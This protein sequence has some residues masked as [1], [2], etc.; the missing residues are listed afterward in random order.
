[1]TEISL[2]YADEKVCF[3]LTEHGKYKKRKLGPV[4]PTRFGV[5]RL[6]LWFLP[7]YDP[8]LVGIRLIPLNWYARCESKLK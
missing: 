2:A 8:L 1:M 5:L 4:N 3:G 6:G 7:R